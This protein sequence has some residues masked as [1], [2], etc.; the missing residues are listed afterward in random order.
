MAKKRNKE[1]VKDDI[2]FIMSLILLILG[3]VIV[4]ISLYIPPIGVIDSSVLTLIGENFV[5]VGA[6]WG[7]G[8]YSKVQMKKIEL[9]HKKHL[10][11]YNDSESEYE[12]EEED[13]I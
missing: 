2:K 11:R 9:H 5:F 4:F 13:L 7:I 10:R 1:N 8:Q 3:V 6:V 12:E